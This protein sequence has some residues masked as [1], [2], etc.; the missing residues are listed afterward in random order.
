MTE[1]GL[2]NLTNYLYDFTE[3]NPEKPAFIHPVRLSFKELTAEIDRI[4]LGLMKT[5]IT[6]GTRTV[7][8]I[9]P[10]IDLFA[11]TFA[12]FRIGAIP[13]LIDPGMGRKRMTEALSGVQ[14]EAF[15]GIPVSHLLRYISPRAFK[16]VNIWISTG[17]RW[18]WKGASLRKMKSTGQSTEPCSVGADDLAA[19]FFTSGSTG[20]PKGVCYKTR[21]LQAQIEYMKTKFKYTPQEIDLCTFPLIGLLI[22]SHGIS[23]A[24]A[25]MDMMHPARL[26][27]KKVIKNIQDYQ[28][29]H[30]FCSPMVL[31]RLADYGIEH[32][33]ILGSM[34]RIM[35]A[36]APVL[37]SILRNIRK[38]L[39]SDAEIHTPYGATEA[40]PVTD[41]LDK[42][43]LRLYD[44]SDS[45]ING[46]CVGYPLE[47][48]KVKI[49]SISDDPVASFG[50][51][52]I[53][54]VDEVGEIVISGPNV[55]EE[56][57][58]NSR[59]NNLAK[60]YNGSSNDVWHRTG[61][62]GRMDKEGRLWFYGRKSQRV[63]ARNKT[64]YTIPVEAVFNK[65]PDV[66]RSA[67]VGVEKDR[68]SGKTPVICVE[69]GKSKKRE[70]YLQEELISMA[71][72]HDITGEIQEFLFHRNFP[73]DP[74]HNAKIYREELTRW[75]NNILSK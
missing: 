23:I 27:P 30:M 11:V 18:F 20:A 17:F 42:E 9:K 22:I 74:R 59:A 32:G 24:M 6:I 75:A 47:G 69:S 7:V 14:A 57:W 15:A 26:N 13:V 52:E 34:K 43:L 68:G 63:V 48:I 37:P 60:I 39:P 50:E 67:L 53:V 49:I 29:T 19:I 40:L 36:G 33:T 72:E 61:D 65:H 56:Y 21:M 3:R 45:Y 12:L 51:V 44:D 70:I 8:L 5:G 46:I 35:T 10:G 55:T 28:C 31:Q 64:Y 62:L 38:L 58:T 16:S 2:H 25:D 4:S 73:V 1:Q 54:A 66:S 71:R 41:I